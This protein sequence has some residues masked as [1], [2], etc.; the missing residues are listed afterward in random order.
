MAGALALVGL[1]FSG[2]AE[3]QGQDVGAILERASAR[4]APVTV[5]CAD[6]HQH[7]SVPLLGEEHEGRGRLCQ[8]RPDRFAMRFTEPKGDV[9]VMDG[10]SVWLYWPSVDPVQVVKLPVSASAGGFDL[11]REFLADPLSKYR[12]TYQGSEVV[13][14]HETHR[15]RL[16]PRGT[17]SY[18]AATVWIDVATPDLRRVRLEEE[19]GSIRTITLENIQIGTPAPAGW[20]SFVAPKGAQ[21][22]S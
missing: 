11:H 2:A 21:V 15:I 9:I 12:A 8:A 6:F 10:T 19:N 18:A 16:V 14:G 22:I 1:S 13:A 7:R 5:L 17:E 3:L 4:Y 20:F